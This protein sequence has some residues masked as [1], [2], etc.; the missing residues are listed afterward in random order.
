MMIALSS[1]EAVPDR[2]LGARPLDRAAAP[3]GH[4]GVA[5]VAIWGHRDRQLQ[6]LVDPAR[7]RR[8]HVSLAQRRR[9]R[10]QRPARVAADVPQRVDAGHRRLP[11][12][13]NQRLGVRHILPFAGP[14]TW[15]QVPVEGSVRHAARRRRDRRRGPSA[16]DRRRRRRRRR[17]R[18]RAAARRREA[19]GHEHARPHPPARRRAATR[20]GPAWPGCGSTRARSGPA[21][22]I[23]TALDHLRLALIIAAALVALV[24]AA[25]LMQ[26]RAV[27]ICLVAIPL[28]LA[29]GAARA[30]PHR[31]HDE[32]ARR[33]GA[34]RSRSAPS[35]TTPS[36]G[37]RTWRAPCARSA[38]PGAIGRRAA[39]CSTRRSAP[40]A[41]WATRR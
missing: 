14:T 8:N 25:F 41:P 33:R 36:A 4:P 28:S 24:L 21:S 38:R 35:S 12:R 19:A 5:N 27:V 6:V 10:G 3:H 37:C 40:A 11:R 32:R 2:A 23:E 16:A 1:A 18:R 34:G 29:D 26:W 7:L 9:H 31:R 17:A 15:R 20:W 30:R 13:P 39:S 22:F